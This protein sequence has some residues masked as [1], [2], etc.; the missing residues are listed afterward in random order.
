[1]ASSFIEENF[2][3]KDKKVESVGE[4]KLMFSEYAEKLDPQ[5][6]ERSKAKISS[7][8]TGPFLIPSQKL[9]AECLPP[10]EACDL[11]SYLV[12]ETSHYANL[13]F[14]ALRSLQAYKFMVSGFISS[15]LGHKMINKF[16]VLAKVRHS[17]RMNDP[18]V[19]L[20]IITNR[21]GT[22]LSAHCAGCMAGLGECCSHIASVLFYIEF[23]TRVNGKLSCTQVKCTWILPTYVKQ[24]DYARI[25]DIDFTSAKKLKENLDKL[26]ENFDPGKP[27][28]ST[29][30]KNPAPRKLKEEVQKPTAEEL[31]QFY[32]S[33]S[34]CKNKPVCLSL[35][36][37]HN[38]AFVS[39]TREVKPITDF[40]DEK[41]LQLSYIDLLKK[42][43]SVELNV[44]DQEV[45][46]TEKETMNQAKGK[47]FYRHRAGRIGASRSKQQVTVILLSLHNHL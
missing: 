45:Q 31:Q 5:V 18:L 16:V 29:I 17:Q 11:L 24:V 28:Q 4:S 37:P 22:I 40:F 14:K 7:I 10:V 20:W 8:G 1:M 42:C 34:K 15:V 36:N 9:Q 38:D 23:W 26:I 47:A 19:V 3:T 35:I 41:N 2:I 39:K 25:K 44:T 27:S 43:H 32:D 12:L 33:L 46:L 6:K 30:P 13:Q 21:D